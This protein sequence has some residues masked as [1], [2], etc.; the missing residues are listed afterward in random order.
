MLKENE[1]QGPLFKNNAFQW[2]QTIGRLVGSGRLRQELPHFGD[3]TSDE[4]RDYLIVVDHH[5]QET[6]DRSMV[7]RLKKIMSH[8][9]IRSES[10][11]ADL[12]SHS[13]PSATLPSEST[14]SFSLNPYHRRHATEI[15]A[16]MENSSVFVNENT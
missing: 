3:D 8:R 14:P 12:L 15:P 16:M 9:R 11:Q 13:T 7:D 5:H 4:V 1:A 10:L 2:G 6:L